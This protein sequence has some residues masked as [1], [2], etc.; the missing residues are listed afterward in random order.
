VNYRTI[1]PTAQTFAQLQRI[2]GIALLLGP[3]RLAPDLMRIDHYRLELKPHQFARHEKG[4][5]PGLKGDVG[6][7]R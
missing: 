5:S 7:G 2:A 1:K 3:L 4:R 6:C